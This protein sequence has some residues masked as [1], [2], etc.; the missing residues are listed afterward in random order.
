MKAY[1]LQYK[2]ELQI[3]F[4]ENCELACQCIVQKYRCDINDISVSGSYEIDPEKPIDLNLLWP[5]FS[6]NPRCSVVTN[7][8]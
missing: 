3:A 6:V 5:Y 8:N 2:D 1:L 7:Y 4:G